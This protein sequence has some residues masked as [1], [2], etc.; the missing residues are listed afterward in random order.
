MAT[1]N[2]QPIA[3]PNISS[4]LSSAYTAGGQV[5]VGA[6]N[7]KQRAIEAAIN[8]RLQQQRMALEAAQFQAKQD[9][10]QQQMMEDR[11]ARD[12]DRAAKMSMAMQEIGA[13]KDLTVLKGEVQQKAMQEAEK[14]RQASPEG[15]A[16]LMRLNA[17]EAL[18]TELADPEVN[19]ARAMMGKNAMMA[20]AGE[21]GYFGYL[22]EQTKAAEMKAASEGGASLLTQS[23]RESLQSKYDTLIGE[24]QGHEAWL[25][26]L[27]DEQ[28]ANLEDEITKRQRDV[29][30]AKETANQIGRRLGI[31]SEATESVIDAPT[32]TQDG[33]MSVKLRDGSRKTFTSADEVRKVYLEKGFSAD[34]NQNRAIAEQLVGVFFGNNGEQGAPAPTQAAAPA[35]RPQQPSQ[36]MFTP[37]GGFMQRR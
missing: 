2:I 11:I 20:F 37:M 5:G 31:K 36:N 34:P 32:P 29:A 19:P 24:V 18:Q 17:L 12:A 6:A 15:K 27:N 3:A 28:K 25:G 1:P 35:A 33:G 8:Q 16:G 13:A 21:P 22:M 14:L 7:V 26:G 23:Q 30:V 4:A 10:A 9:L